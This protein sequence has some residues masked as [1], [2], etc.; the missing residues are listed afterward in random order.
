MFNKCSSLKELNL[1]N[2]YTDNVGN[3]GSM[4]SDCSS[5]KNLNLINFKINFDTYTGDMFSNCF[6]IEELNISNSFYI[7]VKKKQN[8]YL[9]DESKIKIKA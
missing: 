9:P 1:S 7:E 2:F 5:L 6:S 3:M 8:A 4:F